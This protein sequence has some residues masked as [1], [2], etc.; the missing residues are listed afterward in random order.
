MFKYSATFYKKGNMV[1][2]S[3][4]DLMSLMRRA[5]RRADLP[6]V[7]SKGFTPR[8]KISMPR[9]LSL[10][11]ESDS[12]EAIFYFKEEIPPEEARS[13]LNKEFPE[14]IMIN[15]IKKE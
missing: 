10:G 13:K 4:L 9:A 11:K 3:H 12:E 8:V 14:G 2:I 6:F 15:T 7:L 1:Y 5:I